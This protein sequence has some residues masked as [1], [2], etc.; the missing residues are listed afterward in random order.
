MLSLSVISNNVRH[1]KQ[2]WSY[3]LSCSSDWHCSP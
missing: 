3:C 2:Q 1:I